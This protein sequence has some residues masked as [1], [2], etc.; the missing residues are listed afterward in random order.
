MWRMTL[1]T[2]LN[3]NRN[4]TMNTAKFPHD[5]D[6][7]DHELER[8]RAK[9]LDRKHDELIAAVPPALRAQV[10]ADLLNVK[11]IAK[12]F[13][14]IFGPPTRDSRTFHD[15]RDTCQRCGRKTAPRCTC[16]DY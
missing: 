8:R 14:A 7:G 11:V 10:E 3:P 6:W 9:E 13:D 12:T 16:S 2:N 4:P 5:D 1:D 15:D